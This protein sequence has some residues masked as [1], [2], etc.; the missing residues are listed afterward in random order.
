MGTGALLI[1]SGLTNRNSIYKVT[2]VMLPNRI[3]PNKCT[4]LCRITVADGEKRNVMTLKQ[5]VWDAL[6][7]MVTT[8]GSTGYIDLNF[9]GEIIL[10]I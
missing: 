5:F 2:W 9:I 1:L 7:G 10:Q 6:K 8:E 4:K 3:K